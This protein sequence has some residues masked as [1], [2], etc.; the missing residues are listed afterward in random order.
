ML[1]PGR[2]LDALVAENV[3]EFQRVWLPPDQEGEGAGEILIPPGVQLKELESVL[4]KKGGMHAAGFAPAYSTR[5]EDAWKVVERMRSKKWDLTLNGLMAG[6]EAEF[7]FSDERG[8]F[9]DKAS[10][11]ICLAALKALGVSGLGITVESV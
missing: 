5:L 1:E 7:G 8:V 9:S 2:E 4:P 10:H 6:W 3:M 11:A